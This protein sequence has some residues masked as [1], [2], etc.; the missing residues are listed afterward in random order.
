MRPHEGDRQRLPPQSA[1]PAHRTG[2]ARQ[3]ALHLR[4]QCPAPGVRE[5]VH[6]MAPGAHVRSLVGAL[7]PARVTHRVDRH[8]RLLVGE[9]DPLAVSGLQLPPRTLDVVP[10]GVQHIA[11]VLALPGPGPGRDRTVPDG[12]RRVRYEQFLGGAVD[13]PQAVALGARAGRRVRREG[14]GVEPLRTGR[15][16]TGTG[17][18]HAQGVGQRGD[19]AHRGARSGRRPA[20]LQRHG[21]RQTGDLTDVGCPDLVDQ[22][23]RVQGDGLEIAALGLRVDRSEGQGGLSRARDAGEDRE[24]VAR[25]VDVHVAEV[26]FAR[27]AHPYV[28]IMGVDIGGTAPWGSVGWACFCR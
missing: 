13:Q 21:G 10:E 8:H 3:E 28:R 24:R 19:R 15:V 27:A 9:Q 14:V 6:H 26:V 20:L 22:P 16:V 2:C 7:D 18:E 5:R 4:S 11:Q 1:A 25:D 12:Q 17:E 23:A